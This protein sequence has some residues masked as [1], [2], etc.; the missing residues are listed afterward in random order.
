MLSQAGKDALGYTGGGLLAVCLIPQIAKLL[1]TRSARDISL[2]WTLLYLSG[3]GLTMVYLILEGAQAAWIP[4]VI[5]TAA[6]LLTLILKLLFDYTKLG[7]RH[8]VLEVNPDGSVHSCPGISHV[9]V[10]PSEALQSIADWSKHGR[11]ASAHGSRK[12]SQLGSPNQSFSSG[13][14]HRHRLYHYGGQQQQ[15]VEIVQGPA[16]GGNWGATA[17]CLEMNT[18]HSSTLCQGGGQ[19]ADA[20]VARVYPAVADTVIIVAGENKV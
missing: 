6:C 19:E 10:V 20:G 7:R 13:G 3:T 17:T 8:P 15:G 12:G 4:L 5:E 11:T 14:D 16:F 1:I 18:Q 9:A 2:L